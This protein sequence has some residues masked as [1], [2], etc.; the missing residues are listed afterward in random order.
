MIVLAL[1]FPAR[2]EKLDTVLAALGCLGC[3]AE[4]EKQITE[5][6]SLRRFDAK[7][8]AS[9]LREYREGKR[10]G[11][12]MNRIAAGLTD[13]EIERIAAFLGKKP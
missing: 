10:S 6:A 3:H 5:P 7:D 4:E 8:I 1:C 2:A 11:T 12:V 13:D 9:V